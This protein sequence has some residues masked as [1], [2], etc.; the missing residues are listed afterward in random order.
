M[1]RQGNLALLA[2][3]QLPV[4]PRTLS[5]AH[6]SGDPGR[7]APGIWRRVRGRKAGQEGGGARGGPMANRGRGPWLR[8]GAA[9]GVQ[10][11]FF[12]AR[13]TSPSAS[14]WRSRQGREQPRGAGTSSS[15]ESW[16]RPRRRVRESGVGAG[17]RGGGGVRATPHG[18]GAPGAGAQRGVVAAAA[19]RGAR[20]RRW[21]H[22]GPAVPVR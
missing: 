15:R 6:C 21:S 13:A 20:R 3:A 7:K 11:S 5:R 19:V 9:G 8:G 10:Q 1:E 17:R 14:V 2:K 22:G 16:R 4:A 12:A 18:A